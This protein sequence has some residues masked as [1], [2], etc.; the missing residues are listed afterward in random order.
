MSHLSLAKKIESN[1]IDAVEDNM[2]GN[3][4]S[5]YERAEQ[6]LDAVKIGAIVMAFIFY[7]G[8]SAEY[9]LALGSLIT[10]GVAALLI[11]VAIFLHRNRERLEEKFM[12]KVLDIPEPVLNEVFET[13]LRIF[14]TKNGLQLYAKTDFPRYSNQRF[15]LVKCDDVPNGILYE[16]KSQYFDKKQCAESLDLQVPDSEPMAKAWDKKLRSK[17]HKNPDMAIEIAYDPKALN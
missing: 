17:L 9:G 7:G 11:P 3:K 14:A 13:D 1:S 6:K 10:G 12:H 16:I 15:V 4:P 5:P 8:L 2:P